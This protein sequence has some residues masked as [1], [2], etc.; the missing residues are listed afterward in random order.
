MKNGKVHDEMLALLASPA[1]PAGEQGPYL[2]L[3]DGKSRL[4][5]LD[6][7]DP[8]RPVEVASY[9]ACDGAYEVVSANGVIY[10]MQPRGGLWLLRLT[11]P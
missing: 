5:V 11:P 10:V 8:R 1:A 3:A 2:L 4:R 6:L 9:T 7:R